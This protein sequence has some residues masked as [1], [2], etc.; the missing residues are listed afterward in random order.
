[1]LLLEAGRDRLHRRPRLRN[2]DLRFQPADDR[3]PTK[4]PMILE[5]LELPGKHIV[6]HADGDPEHVR[7]SERHDSFETRRRH[8]H[9]RAGYTLQGDG[10]AVK[11]VVRTESAR[12]QS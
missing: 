4:A 11:L 8:A 2:A 7:P 9:D 5:I 12:P 10:P 1:M 3:E 6:A